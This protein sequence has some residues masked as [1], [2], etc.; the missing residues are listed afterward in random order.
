LFYALGVGSV[1]FG[2][3]FWWFWTSMVVMTVGELI[4]MP[5]ATTHVANLAPVDMRGRYMSIFGL[6]WGIAAAVGPILGG[7]LNDNFGPHTIWYGGLAAGLLSALA[8]FLLYRR[9][10]QPSQT[11]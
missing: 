9:M 10:P 7:F 6:T 8:F 3:G 4:I 2:Q 1:A 11:I 5:T